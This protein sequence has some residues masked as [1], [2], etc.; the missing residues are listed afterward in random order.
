MAAVASSLPP[1]LQYPNLVDQGS[2]VLGVALHVGVQAIRVF[3]GVA[4]GLQG[5]TPGKGFGGCALRGAEVGYVCPVCV[6][7]SIQRG[8]WG[9]ISGGDNFTGKMRL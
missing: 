7:V 9:V 3:Q 8:G 1:H 5:M 2:Y 6:G 4:V